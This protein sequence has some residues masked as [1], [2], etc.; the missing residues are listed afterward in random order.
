M[1]RPRSALHAFLHLG[2]NKYRGLGSSY[3]P[4][5]VKSPSS[6]GSRARIPR[7]VGPRREAGAYAR[8]PTTSRTSTPSRSVKTLWRERGNLR[9]HCGERPCDLAVILGLGIRRGGP[10]LFSRKLFEFI[11]GEIRNAFGER[12][13]RLD[14]LDPLLGDRKGHPGV[15]WLP[16]LPQPTVGR[17]RLRQAREDGYA[18]SSSSASP[19]TLQNTSM[20]ISSSK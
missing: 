4:E 13:S 6:C 1:Q 2:L 11:L 9:V 10:F 18:L 20:P 17:S 5:S 7:R 16:C 14:P 15:N 19:R 3:R 8:S 12:D